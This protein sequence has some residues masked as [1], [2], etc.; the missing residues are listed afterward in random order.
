MK[1][2]KRIKEIRKNFDFSKNYSFFDAVSFFKEKSKVNFIES[3]DVS[4]NL[5]INIKDQ[6]QHVKNFII[7]PNKFKNPYKII[8]F[9]QGK[10]AEIAKNECVEYVGMHD[11]YEKVK[12]DKVNFDVVISSFEAIDIVNSLANILGPK[13]LMPDAKIGTI[14]N[15]IFES[16]RNF[17][18]GQM[19]LKSDKYG[20]VHTSIG[21]I[22][23]DIN[24]LEENFLCLI[25]KIKRIKP[26]S[27]KGNYIKKIFLSTTMGI[28]ISLNL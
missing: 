12:Y 6:S 23:F 17:K 11:L 19:K 1:Y 3:L 22:N 13:G 26:I 8:V 9:A 15:N 4:I 2:G 16:I 25:N 20:I 14:T 24:K 5:N 27:V 10:N 18:R 28:G 21:K 7:F